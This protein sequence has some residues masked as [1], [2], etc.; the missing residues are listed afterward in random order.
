MYFTLRT[1]RT[2]SVFCWLVYLLLLQVGKRV[3][4]RFR[5]IIHVHFARLCLCGL[6]HSATVSYVTVLTTE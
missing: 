1:L 3:Y 6:L 4:I 2:L 5:F